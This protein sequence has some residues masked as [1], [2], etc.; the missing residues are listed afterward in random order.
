MPKQKVKKKNGN[1][2][3]QRINEIE[4]WFFEEIN[5][6]GKPLAKLTKRERRLKLTRLSMKS[7]MT[8]T[9]KL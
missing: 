9:K 3:I 1:E 4:R 7:D 6:I 8:H 5:N 2:K